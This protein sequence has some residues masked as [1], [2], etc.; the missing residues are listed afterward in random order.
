MTGRGLGSCKTNEINESN[1]FTGRGFGRGR[2]MGN[3]LGAGLGRFGFGRVQN[4]DES[5]DK[6]S[7]QIS[8]L[9]EEVKKLINRF[10]SE[11]R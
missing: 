11:Q 5:T 3:G 9:T 10:S 2:K 1:N 6:L 7:Q 4:H 8:S